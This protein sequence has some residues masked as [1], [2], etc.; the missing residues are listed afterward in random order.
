MLMIFCVNDL[1]NSENFAQAIFDE[2]LIRMKLNLI[3]Y[4][5]IYIS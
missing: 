5:D 2:H 4:G 1:T 3:L